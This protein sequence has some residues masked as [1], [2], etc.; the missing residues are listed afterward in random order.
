MTRLPLT[1]LAL[2]ALAVALTGCGRKGPLEPPGG[3]PAAETPGAIIGLTAPRS[4][5]ETVERPNK[6]FILD[7][8]I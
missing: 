7:P 2:L 3:R 6:P 1:I 4:E 8:L 5:P